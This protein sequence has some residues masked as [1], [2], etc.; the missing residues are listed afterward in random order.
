MG[1]K[2]NKVAEC[3]VT[4]GIPRGLLYYKY[5]ILWESFLY[6]LGVKYIVSPDTNKEI[7]AKG[8]NIAVD[9]TCLPSKIYMGH[10]D[11]LIGRCDYIL[12]PR[13][14]DFGKTGTVCTKHQAMYDV[15]TNTFRDRKPELLVFEVEHDS[16]EAEVS[17]FLK[18]GRA[19][20]KKRAPIMLAYLN[21]KQSQKTQQ[22]MLLNDQKKL[23]NTE[24]IK[25]LVIAHLYNANDNFIGKPIF[26]II[27]RLGAVPIKGN[28][29]DE[30]TAV[31]KSEELSKTLPWIFNK[32]LLGAIAEYRS[33]VNG[34]VLM[35]SFPC[36]PD[37][38]VNEIIVR[39]VKDIPILNLVLDGQEALAGIETRLESFIDIINYRKNERHE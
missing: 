7:L 14:A 4:I 24:K 38:M 21:A 12:V 33:D 37:S 36:G 10:V 9:E 17:A 32:E 28:I 11:W 25:I 5:G 20:G 8:V 16:L 34:I 35:S 1:K 22:M 15:I 26:N 6:S 23:L 27:R 30:K 13:M 19:I 2:K 31:R 18:M 29:I 39:R 3:S